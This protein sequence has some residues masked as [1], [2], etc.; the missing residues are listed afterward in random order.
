MDIL[1]NKINRNVG[2]NEVLNYPE[3]IGDRFAGVR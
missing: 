2:S 1:L 3:Y